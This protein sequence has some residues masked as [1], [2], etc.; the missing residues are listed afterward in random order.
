MVLKLALSSSHQIG[1]PKGEE[2]PDHIV[3]DLDP[4]EEG[5]T[6]EE[7][8]CASNETQLG[9][10]CHLHQSIFASIQKSEKISC[11]HLDVMFNL[12]EGCCVKEDVDS[13]QWSMLN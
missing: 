6:S 8:H 3:D 5:E 10:V 13:L 1:N 12:V 4:T 11:F 9:L 7:A 2:E